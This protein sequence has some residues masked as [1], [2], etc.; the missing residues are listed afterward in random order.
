MAPLTHEFFVVKALF[1]DHVYHGH[2]ES[3]IGARPELKPDVCQLRRLGSPW[4]DDDEFDALRLGITYGL[5]HMGPALGRIYPDEQ[6]AFGWHLILGAF[7]KSQ[8][9]SIDRGPTQHSCA[10][11]DT[12]GMTNIGG[13][14]N[15]WGAEQ[16]QKPAEHPH[17]CPQGATVTGQCLRSVFTP[18]FCQL[19]SDLLKGL[20]PGDL[21]PLS[22]TLFPGP[23]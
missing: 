10:H 13:V 12:W 14:Y 3:S 7:L 15:V 18:K 20:L 8:K 22:L 4:I 17:G 1:D 23:L 11:V 21:L 6:N 9:G 5:P 19:P 2:E 16:I